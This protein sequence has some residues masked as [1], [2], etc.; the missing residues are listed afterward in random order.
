[1]DPASPCRYARQPSL[2]CLYPYYNGA[3]PF[4]QG[5][6][7]AKWPLGIASARRCAFPVAAGVSSRAGRARIRAAR[8][9][10]IPVA[11]KGPAPRG[12]YFFGL[13]FGGAGGTSGGA[14]TWAPAAW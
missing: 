10:L 12:G 6:K 4:R 5:S 7:W 2:A 3:S 14:E 8:P 11:G 13:G 9:R 1:M